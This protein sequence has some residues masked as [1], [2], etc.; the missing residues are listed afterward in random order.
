MAHSI[1][2][3]RARSRKSIPIQIW[4]ATLDLHRNVH[5]EPGL[6][7][8]ALVEISA[9]EILDELDAFEVD[10]VATIEVSRGLQSLRAIRASR[11]AVLT[12]LEAG[13]T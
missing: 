6:E 4:L 11:I 1:L 10:N 12:A 3:P 9:A 5:V 2:L 7:G 8:L 13:S